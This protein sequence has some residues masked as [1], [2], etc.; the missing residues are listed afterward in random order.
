MR[1]GRE[2]GSHTDGGD[3]GDDFTKLE[4]I[5][6][7]GLSGSIESDH[8]NSHLLLPPELVEELRKCET[9]G[10]GL[11]NTFAGKG[12]VAVIGGGLASG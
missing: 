9:H 1:S 5:E 6:N 11:A 7:G 4:L 12:D 2:A 8:Q 3:G 10:G